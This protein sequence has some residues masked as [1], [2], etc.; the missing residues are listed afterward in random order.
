[1]SGLSSSDWRRWRHTE[2]IR[3]IK[4]ARGCEYVLDDGSVCG[5]REDASALE[6][7]HRDPGTKSFVISK[8]NLRWS[9][10]LREIDKCD[11]LCSNHH[12]IRTR[13]DSHAIL[14]MTPKTIGDD[15]QL[16]FFE[17]AS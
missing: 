1:M 8:V 13:N 14:W 7:D 6:F 10:I 16:S 4:L 3:A 5:F 11:V 9:M 15:P 12:K 17:A 2:A